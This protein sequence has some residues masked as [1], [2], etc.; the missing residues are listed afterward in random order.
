M[1]EGAGIII[2]F[3]RL[4]APDGSPSSTST[5]QADK[6]LALLFFLTEGSGHPSKSLLFQSLHSY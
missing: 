2:L 1:G 4:A 5:Q 3:R 6:L